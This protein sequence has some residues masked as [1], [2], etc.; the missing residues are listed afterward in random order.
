MKDEL[1]QLAQE[2]ERIDSFPPCAPE[3]EEFLGEIRIEILNRIEDLLDKET[4]H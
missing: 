1:D 4:I 2:L 3:V